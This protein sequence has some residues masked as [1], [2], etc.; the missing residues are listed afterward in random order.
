MFSFPL[1]SSS[2]SLLILLFFSHN[3]L[4]LLLMR[5]IKIVPRTQQRVMT[6]H[7]VH[8]QSVRSHYMTL[9][10]IVSR[11]RTVPLSGGTSNF[12]TLKKI[13]HKS[14]LPKICNFLNVNDNFISGV[15]LS[16]NIV[17][18]N[19]NYHDRY[20]SLIFKSWYK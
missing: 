11:A 8:T 4:R 16:A 10:K 7:L 13:W 15:V 19:C 2:S 5:V 9:R 12:N 1:T 18:S 6:S 3:V 14:L 20:Y 17:K